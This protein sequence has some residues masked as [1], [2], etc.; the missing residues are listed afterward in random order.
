MLITKRKKLKVA[1]INTPQGPLTV[2]VLARDG[3][4][5]KLGLE[6]PPGCELEKEQK[7]ETPAN[8]NSRTD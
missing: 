8:A 4:E 5:F 7:Q 1:T 6:L 2:Q 3:D